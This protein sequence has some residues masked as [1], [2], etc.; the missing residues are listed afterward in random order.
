MD[1]VLRF[2]PKCIIDDP[3]SYEENALLKTEE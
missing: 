1:V 3:Y 2:I